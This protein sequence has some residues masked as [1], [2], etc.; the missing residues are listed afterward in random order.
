[1]E[2]RPRKRIRVR[3]PALVATAVLVLGGLA[4]T[5]TAAGPPQEGTLVGSSWWWGRDDGGHGGHHRGGRPTTEPTDPDNGGDGGHGDHGGHGDDPV[6]GPDPSLFA[7][8]EEA[9]PLP[10]GPGPDGNASTGTFTTDCGVNDIGVRNSENVIVAPGVAHGAQHT[11]D[12]VGNTDVQRFTE[13]VDANNAILAAGDTTCPDGDRSMHYWPVLRDLT[14]EGEDAD[15]SGGGLDGNVGRII[16]PS[17]VTIEFLGNA[18]GPVTAMPEFLQIITGNARAVTAEGVNANARWTCT[19]FEDRAFPDRYPLCPE[20]SD[21]V[22]VL[23]F[24]GCWNGTDATSE[25]KRSHIVFAQEDGS[26]PDGFTAVPRLRHTLVYE[27]PEGP[28][29]A[30]DGFPDQGRHPITDHSDHIN[31]MPDELMAEVVECINGGLDCRRP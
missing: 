2:E 8:I 1:M 30:L 14:G 4:L 6:T 27:V 15:L 26:C 12:Y 3:L 10:A 5:A 22:R 9:P 21:V 23:E 11:H 16:V 18:R 13:D 25:D 7:P 29:F 24:P 31:V 20:G 17:A 19:G 28:E